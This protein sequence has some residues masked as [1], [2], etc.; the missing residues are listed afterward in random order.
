MANMA[1][2]LSALCA[3][4]T[5]PP[6]F[7]FLRFL[8]LISVRG[9]VDPRAIVRPEG[10]GKL[11]KNHL[12]R[13]WSRDG[14]ANFIGVL[15][16]MFLS[17]KRS[18]QSRTIWPQSKKQLSPAPAVASVTDS[19]EGVAY[20]RYIFI[21]NNVKGK[22]PVIGHWRPIGLWD[23]ETSTFPRQSAH[24]WWGCQPYAPA[25]LTVTVKNLPG[26]KGSQCI[27]IMY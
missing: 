6:R 19:L 7:L 20:M 18:L 3:S 16:C 11:E 24:R 10:L 5:L 14:Y 27:C 8:V 23:V 26:V 1:A 4:H 2:R 9:W 17:I 13:M 21:V 25:D 22:I 15:V 12:I